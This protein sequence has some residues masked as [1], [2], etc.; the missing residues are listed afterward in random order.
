MKERVLNEAEKYPFERPVNQY[1]AF[2][3][4]LVSRQKDDYSEVFDAEVS[5]VMQ[6]IKRNGLK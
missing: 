5:L 2:V 3:N 4:E 6:P 1:E